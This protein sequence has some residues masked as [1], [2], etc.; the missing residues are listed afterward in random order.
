MRLFNRFKSRSKIPAE[1]A[2]G[3]SQNTN[4]RKAKDAP[5]SNQH[6]WGTA[7]NALKFSVGALGSV[8][9]NI[10][11]GLPGAVDL[12]LETVDRIKVHLQIIFCAFISKLTCVVDSV[13]RG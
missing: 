7:L 13:D 6:V 4:S 10:V 8:G 2:D 1:P 5:V 3:G 11:P 9:S 12:L